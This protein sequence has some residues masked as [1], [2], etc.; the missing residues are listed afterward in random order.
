MSGF[1]F[2]C[3]GCPGLWVHR[4]LFSLLPLCSCTVSSIRQSHMPQHFSGVIVLQNLRRFRTSLSMPLAR[5]RHAASKS[6]TCIHAC[7]QPLLFVLSKLIASILGAFFLRM[8]CTHQGDAKCCGAFGS[9]RCFRA[10]LSANSVWTSAGCSISSN[11]SWTARTA[12]FS[13]GM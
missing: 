6:S 10:G 4:K 12:L 8:Q 11:R 7:I 1:S 3:P 13:R 9:R 5:R 2:R